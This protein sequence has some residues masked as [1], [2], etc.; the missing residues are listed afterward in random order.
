MSFNFDYNSWDNDEER[1][2]KFR[3]MGEFVNLK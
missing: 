1:Y 2:Q 3:K